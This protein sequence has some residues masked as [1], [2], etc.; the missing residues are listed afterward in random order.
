VVVRI[1]RFLRAV[2][3][4]QLREVKAQ[5]RANTVR[6][7]PDRGLEKPSMMISL[8]RVGP[9]SAES[10]VPAIM[11]IGSASCLARRFPCLLSW[12]RFPK[13]VSYSNRKL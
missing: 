10:G 7:L 13:I 11:V 1:D 2:E 9:S 8:A 12:G 5:E 4:T 6:T 3:I